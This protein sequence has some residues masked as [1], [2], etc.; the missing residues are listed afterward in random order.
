MLGDFLKEFV[1]IV[2][3]PCADKKKKKKRF[4]TTVMFCKKHVARVKKSNRRM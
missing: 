3:R 4:Y 1:E 2:P